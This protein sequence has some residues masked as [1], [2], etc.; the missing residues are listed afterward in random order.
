M[1]DAFS[2]FVGILAAVLAIGVVLASAWVVAWALRGRRRR[3]AYEQAGTSHLDLYFSE[4]FPN[5][6]QEF[7]LVTTGRFESWI[8]GVTARVSQ[9]TRDVDLARSSRARLDSRLERLEKRLGEV[10]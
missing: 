5:L 6:V 9:I 4:H 1:V 2:L 3:Q 10:E 7:D 8:R